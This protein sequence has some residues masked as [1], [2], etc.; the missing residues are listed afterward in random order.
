[1]NAGNAP[2]PIPAEAS[3][4]Q[5]A[6][7]SAAAPVPQP[8]EYTP[9]FRMDNDLTGIGGWLI[10]V[11]IG[12]GIG[13]LV[14]LFGIVTDSQLLFN[15]RFQA[16]MQLKPGLEAIVF[17][18][19]VTNSFFL[20]YILMLNF[21]FY[22]KRRSF[23]MFMIFLL[24]AQ[25]VTMLIDHLWASRFSPSS[26]VFSVLQALVAAAIWIPYF[27]NSIRVEQTFVN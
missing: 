19:L 23:P 27:L 17:Y 13:P 16:A 9:A 15:G 12:L 5:E 4:P 8:A 25:F 20:V 21:L 3:A 1:V 10:L 11:A 26:Q 14:R 2:E 22:S 18:E 7:V 6:V 24:A